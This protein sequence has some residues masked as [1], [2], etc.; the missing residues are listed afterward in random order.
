MADVTDDA[1]VAGA[2]RDCPRWTSWSTTP[3]GQKGLEPVA[4]ANLEHWRWMWGDE[5]AGDAA[6]DPAL[7]AGLIGSGDGLIVTVLTSVAA[8]EVYDSGA[9]LHL[10]QTRAERLHR[11]LLRGLLGLPVR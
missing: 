1:A 11:T 3:A 6:G 2:R 4:E 8:L 7:T 5:R 9:G 10:R